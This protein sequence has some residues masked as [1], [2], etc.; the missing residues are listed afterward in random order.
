LNVRFF[1]IFCLL[2]LL[3][4]RATAGNK[5]WDGGGGDVSWHNAANWSS[6]A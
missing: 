5:S 3:C 2:S 6:C 4:E 1:F